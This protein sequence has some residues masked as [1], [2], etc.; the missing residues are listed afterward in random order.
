[1]DWL[2]FRHLVYQLLH[3]NGLVLHVSAEDLSVHRIHNYHLLDEFEEE[4]LLALVLPESFYEFLRLSRG[5]TLIEQ[6][7][8][9]A[10]ELLPP[11]FLTQIFAFLILLFKNTYH[12]LP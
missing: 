10:N 3:E 2:Q 9:R 12:I 7:V 8:S 6:F 4:L 5:L 11:I 1:M